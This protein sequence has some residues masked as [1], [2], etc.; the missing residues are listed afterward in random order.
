MLKKSFTILAL[1]LF[2]TGVSLSQKNE[3]RAIKIDPNS[4]TEV[5][6]SSTSSGNLLKPTGDQLL[7]T[8]YD[9]AGNNSIPNMVYMYDFTGDG[10]KD[11]VATAMQRFDATNR[12]VKMIVGNRTDGFTD[13]TAAHASAGWGTLQVGEVGPWANKGIVFYHAGGNSWFSSTD[14]TSLTPTFNAA[15]SIAGNFPSFVYKDNGDVYLTNTNGELFKSTDQTTFTST[16]VFFDP[17][18]YYITDYNS[19]YILKASPNGQYLAHVG[20]WTGLSGGAGNGGP[21]GAHPDSTDFIGMNYSSDGG[22]TWTFELLGRDGL[23]PV[24]NRT[25]YL[26]IFENFG[27]VNF[28]VDDNGVVHVGVNGY[29]YRITATDTSFGFP[30]LYWNSRDKNWIA[31]TS[32]AVEVDY[33]TANAGNG[34]N[35]PGNGL[36]NSYVVPTISKDGSKV[37]VLWQGPEYAGTP[38]TG[39]INTWTP[40]ATSAYPVHYTDLYYAVSGDG[41]HNFS[42]PELLPNQSAKLVQESY[43]S[44]NNYMELT[45]DSMHVDFLYMIDAIPGTSLFAATS[46]DYSNEASNNSSWNYERLTLP[47]PAAPTSVDITFQVDMRV[48]AKK[49]FFKPATDVVTIPGAFNN[50]LNEPPAN[51]DKVMSDV[52]GDSIYSKTITLTPGQTYEYKY[53]IGLGWE[54]KDE[55]GGQPNRSIVAPGANTVLAPVYFNNEAMPTGAPTNVTFEID[56]TLPAK[57]NPDFL[58]RKV[59]VA[60]D[61]TDWG[62]SAIEMTDPNSDSVYTVTTPINSGQLIHYKFI[63]STGAASSGS[64]ENNFPTP[65]SNRETWI[66]DG[67][68]TISKFWNDEDPN[69]TLADGNIFFEVNMSVANEL[70]VFNPNVDSVQLRGGFNGWNDSEPDKSL[71]NQDPSNPNSWYLNVPFVQNVVGSNQFYKYYIKNGAGSTPYANTGWEVYLGEPT[72][73]SDR[74]RPVTFEGIPNQEIEVKYFDGIHTDWVIPV[75]TTVQVNFSVDMS[76]ATSGAIPFVPATDTVYWIPRHPMFYSVN[77]L[78]WGMETRILSL[79]DPNSDMIYTGTLT[80]NGPSFNGFLYQYAYVHAGTFVQEDGSQGEAR[81]RFVAQPSARTFTSPFDMPQDV[82]TNG[83]KPE[84]TGPVTSIREFNG[85]VVNT[86]SLEQNYPNPFNPATIIRF[87]IPEAG[88]VNLAIYNLLGEKVGEILNQELVSGSYEVNY[89]ASKLSS[90]VYLYTIKAGNYTASKKMILMK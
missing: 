88:M 31:L 25:G 90:G 52:D 12:Q 11:L 19:E 39:I 34:Y 46:P 42:A 44:P 83:E 53:N 10:N 27:Q 74:N 73:N 7:F 5:N 67:D 85:G 68:Q 49:G 29:G 75:G 63:H 62:T 38:G 23:T 59:Y 71:M 24:F 66:V 21:G 45:T 65:S 41:G 15:Q 61:F 28:V 79:T 81:V 22:A 43:P 78:P 4:V 69:V 58:S 37:V 3:Q 2:I 60:G 89:D 87:S 48:Q 26:P 13:F 9:Y 40:T 18:G 70:G 57:A 16:G 14:M 32:E 47:L 1:L 17:S 35:R 6:S 84:E 86:F 54:G 64:W 56:M 82:W 8:D 80:L 33:D 36:G 20:M 76:P 30:A 77:G 55:L 50:W 72:S 51:T